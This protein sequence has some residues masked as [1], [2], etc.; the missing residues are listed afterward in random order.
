VKARAA[1]RKALRINPVHSGAR[2][3]MDL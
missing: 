3:K 1:W 2:E